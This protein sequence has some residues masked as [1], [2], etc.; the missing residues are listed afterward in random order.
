MPS[1]PP[2]LAVVLVSRLFA[3]EGEAAVLAVWEDLAE[4]VEL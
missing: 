4:A 3:F 2:M 1:A